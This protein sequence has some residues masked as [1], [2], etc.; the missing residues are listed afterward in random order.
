M[1]QRGIE[2]LKILTKNGYEAY[3]IGGYPRDLYL[4]KNS[5]DIDICTNATPKNLLKI[6]PN[7]NSNNIK[8]GNIIVDNIQIT[9]YRKEEYNESRYPI[10]TYV[11]TL[12]EDIERRDFTIN[13]L[14]IDY[15]GNYV[16]LLGAINDLNSKIIRVVGNCDRKMKEDP[17]RILRAIRFATI[18]DFKLDNNLI[19]IIRKYGC[20][21]RNLS[22]QKKKT[23]LFK[24]L[25][26][27][28]KKIGISLLL[29]YNLDKYLEIYNLDSINFNE[30]I[31]PQIDIYNKYKEVKDD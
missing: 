21:I 8:Y 9:T 27:D 28:N 18:L 14:C 13:T 7:C 3:I 6:F 24:I 29:E 22:Y 2:I 16:D 23:E 19:V 11:K 5:T 10:V 15:L 1:Y 25:S 4:S 30:D 26:S 31:L 20:L 12:K 17:L